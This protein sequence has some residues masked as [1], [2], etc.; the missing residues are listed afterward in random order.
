MNKIAMTTQI[1]LMEP[2]NIEL[3]TEEEVYWHLSVFP[4]KMV[5]AVFSY[6][7]T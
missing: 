5:D 2:I 1:F 7:A 3:C 6:L 4:P